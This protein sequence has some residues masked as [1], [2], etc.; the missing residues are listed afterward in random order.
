MLQALIEK[1]PA[2]MVTKPAE[3]DRSKP[4]HYWPEGYLYVTYCLHVRSLV[5][6]IDYH[7]EQQPNDALNDMRTWWSF[8]ENVED[9][10]A[11]AI[12]F[13]DLFA[14]EKPD[15]RMPGFFRPDR[16]RVLLSHH[17]PPELPRPTG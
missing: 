8:K 2:R 6:E 16:G 13:L 17:L 1:Q 11:L 15:W 4:V 14:G 10:P 9:D 3:I 7:G 12:G 5:I